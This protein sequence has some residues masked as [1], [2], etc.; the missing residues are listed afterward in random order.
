MLY[1]KHNLLLTDEPLYCKRISSKKIMCK[2]FCTN[3]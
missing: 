2:Y 1:R 3:N